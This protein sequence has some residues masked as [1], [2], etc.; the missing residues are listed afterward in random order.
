MTLLPKATKTSLAKLVRSKGYE[1]PSI[2]QAVFSQS[3]RSRGYFLSWAD[4]QGERHHAYYSGA[5]GRPVLQVDKDW[6]D[7][8]LAEV[9]HF[10]L[11]EKVEEKEKAPDAA[12]TA[13]RASG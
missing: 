8:T 5:A 3:G 10:G 11:V 13:P 2:R 6:I 12:G 7:L 1:L 9:I 4:G